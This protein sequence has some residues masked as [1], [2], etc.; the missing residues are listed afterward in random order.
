MAD[1][2]TNVVPDTKAAEAAAQAAIEAA[3]QQAEL[4]R[5]AAETTPNKD[6]ADMIAKLVQER[7]DT[8]LASIKKSLDNSY[9]QRDDALAKIAAFEAKEKEAGL[10]KLEEEGKFKE[11]YELRLAEAKAVNETLKK[12]NT[13]LSRDVSVR[14]SLKGLAFRNDKASDMAFKEI[15]GNLVQNESGTWVHRSGISVRDYCEA[16]SKDEDQSFLFKAKPNTGGGSSSSNS[17]SGTPGDSNQS[18]SLF[19][20]SQ[21]E[22]L[23]LAAEGKLPKK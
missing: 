12:Q 8:Q 9:K 1:E 14:D 18:K 11:A 21:A 22:V 2:N 20:M 6:D 17:G 15:T 4:A 5:K 7:L 10:K 3:Q 16:F 13:E 19:S 23:K